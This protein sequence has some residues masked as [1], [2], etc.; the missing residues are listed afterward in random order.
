M[1]QRRAGAGIDSALR[2]GKYDGGVKMSR[3]KIIKTTMA[4]L[5]KNEGAFVMSPHNRRYLT[6]FNSTSGAVILFKDNAY[7]ITDARYIEGARQTVKDMEIIAAENGISEVVSFL[8]KKHGIKSLAAEADFMTVSGAVKCETDLGSVLLNLDGSLDKT[9]E[10]MRKIKHKDELWSIQKAQ[11]LTD[12]AFLHILDL[13][14]PG[15]TEIEIA[16]ELENHMRR[17]GSQG[18]AFE[19]IVA[20][21]ENSSKPHMTPGKREIKTGDFVT[22]DFGA[23]VD[24]YCADMTRTVA[25]G[26]IT[27][28][29]KAVYDIVLKSQ[30]DCLS[31]LKP[32]LTGKEADKIARDVI[33]KS[34]YGKN[35]SHAAGHC[36]G[37]EIHEEPRLSPCCDE[38]LLP[39]MVV[40][41]EPG[42]YLEGLFGVRIEDMALITEKGIKNLTKSAKELINI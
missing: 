14:R 24:G 1:R 37:I 3:A 32:G 33:E 31:G 26:K 2:R 39:G 30:V 38:K 28:E 22:M 12:D 6:K 4:S 27:G 17:R 19:T 40:T 18:V 41:V 9:L 35:F 16:L 13:I 20:S 10:N 23:V 34:G 25:V 42:I 11:S 8:C 21:G 15:V 36:V 29:Q 7:F 5:N